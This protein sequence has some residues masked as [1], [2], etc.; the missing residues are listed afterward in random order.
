MFAGLLEYIC[1]NRFISKNIK[2]KANGVSY[3]K[4]KIIYSQNTRTLL[5][6]NFSLFMIL[7]LRESDSDQTQISSNILRGFTYGT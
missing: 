6:R 3:T 5:G 7:W 2:I 4:F 1:N